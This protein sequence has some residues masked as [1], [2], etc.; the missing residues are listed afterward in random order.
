MNDSSLYPKIRTLRGVG[1]FSCKE[2]EFEADFEA[3]H[4]PQNTIITTEIDVNQSNSLSFIKSNGYWTLEGL[5]DENLNIYAESLI[6]THLSGNRLTLS[7]FKDFTINKSKVSSFTSAQFPLVGLYEGKFNTKIEKW[8]ISILEDKEKI[9]K[10]QQKS[11]NWN[12]QLE[13]L[14]LKLVKPNSSK[15]TFLSK[16]KSITSLLSLAL[17]NDIVFNRQLYYQEDVLFQEDW[18]RMV[19]HNFGAGASIPNFDL[20]VF[21]KKTLQIY[22][23]WNDEKKTIFYSTVTGIN[24]S[25]RGFL[26]D[27]ILRICIAWEG[28]AGSWSKNKKKSNPELEPLKKLLLETVEGSNLP[29]N[30][31]KGFIKT[32][33]SGS[34]DWE[35]LINYLNNFSNQYLLNTDKLKLDFKSLV[36]VRDNIAHSGFYEKKYTTN[37]ILDL[38]YNHKL[39]LQVIL[40]RELGYDGLVVTS[41]NNWTTYTKMEELIK[42]SL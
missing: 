17:G 7:S 38:I 15:D 12:V 16:A 3:I 34:L 6:F 10:I 41:E 8:E 32:R 25:S 9:E 31:D 5:T 13:G 40:L 21:L 26:E 24:S 14:C 19:D 30:I 33:I 36:K 11:K 28:L 42:P 4:F 20:G 39:A 23:N 27:R 35:R 18:R 22:E 2:L 29:T 37:F 1:I